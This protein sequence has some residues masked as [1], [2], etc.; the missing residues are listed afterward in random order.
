MEHDNLNMEKFRQNLTA[1][2]KRTYSQQQLNELI[3]LAH[4]IALTFLK[5]KSRKGS[6]NIHFLR[7]SLEDAAYDCIADLFKR[8][9]SDKFLVLSV[10]FSAFELSAC[11]NG[12]LFS[13]F[14]RLVFTKVNDGI[15]RL[16]HDVDPSLSRIIRN[17][18][19]AVQ[20]LGT[21][22]E[23]HRF[24]EVYIAPAHCDLLEHLPKA[25]NDHIER[26]LFEHISGNENTL[27]LVGVLAR[28]LREQEE[29]SRMVGLFQVAFVL[30]SLFS[31]QSLIN[32]GTIFEQNELSNTEAMETV[33]VAIRKVQSH[34]Y[35]KY[36]ERKKLSNE[37][38]EIYFTVIKKRF[39]YMLL[40]GSA[41]HESLYALLTR[42]L[43]DLTEDQYKQTHRARLE[44]FYS[45]SCDEVVKDI[46]N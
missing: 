28:I 9:T 3:F 23:L 37:L 42:F 38:F 12:E 5:N 2:L 29:F 26:I 44:Y 20:S 24:G 45:L 14:R 32:A 43:N 41:D 31:R 40:T 1:I 34:L 13:H 4:S 18:K 15:V 39:E 17:I 21:Y 16:Y 30:R 6:L 10:Y 7:I 19:L 35:T 27:E 25:D 11:S 36:V 22:V 33:T 8:D 46:R